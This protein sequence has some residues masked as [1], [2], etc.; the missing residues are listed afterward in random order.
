MY[1]CFYVFFFSTVRLTGVALRVPSNSVGQQKC[2]SHQTILVTEENHLSGPPSPVN[3]VGR[4]I[5]KRLD[6]PEF[7]TLN[8]LSK[9]KYLALTDCATGALTVPFSC[10]YVTSMLET[11]MS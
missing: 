3:T 7:H 8:L 9:G 11:K 4:E 5:G 1:Q 10:A 6:E 2:N